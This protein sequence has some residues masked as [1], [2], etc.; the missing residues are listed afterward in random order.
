[1]N[2]LKYAKREQGRS[3]LDLSFCRDGRA[4]E[5]VVAD[6]GPGLPEGFDPLQSKGLGMRLIVSLVRQLDGTFEAGNAGEGA[7]FVVRC[8][9]EGP[10]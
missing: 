8:P 6:D 4:L 3:H 2:A 7:R 5:L 10:G 9:D 1:M